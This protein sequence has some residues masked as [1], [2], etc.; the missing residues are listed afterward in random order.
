M[1]GP[2]PFGEEGNN[3]VGKSLLVADPFQKLGLKRLNLVPGNVFEKESVLHDVHLGHGHSLELIIFIFGIFGN[4]IYKVAMS[5]QPDAIKI[6][7]LRYL[8]ELRLEAG[9]R[10]SDVADALERPQSYVSKYE[11]GEKT[12]DVFELI[13]I[14]KVLDVPATKVIDWIEQNH[15]G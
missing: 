7:F 8:R 9:L 10:Q 11:S 2:E 4:R 3:L 6:K 12:L 5:T 15:A 13:A 14:C 1:V